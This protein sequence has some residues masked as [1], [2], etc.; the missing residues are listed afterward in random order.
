MKN[1]TFY[2]KA[3][4]RKN[5]VVLESASAISRVKFIGVGDRTDPSAADGA[6]SDSRGVHLARGD[7]LEEGGKGRKTVLLN[8]LLNRCQSDK[9]IGV[10]NFFSI[11]ESASLRVL[12]YYDIKNF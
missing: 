4:V 5:K 11:I 8:Y 12:L 2:T 9:F 1:E 10:H 7:R 3:V 6:E